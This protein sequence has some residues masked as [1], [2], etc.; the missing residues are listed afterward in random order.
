MYKYIYLK[1]SQDK[2]EPEDLLLITALGEDG[3]DVEGLSSK[4]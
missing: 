3:G 4:K 1:Y 2:L